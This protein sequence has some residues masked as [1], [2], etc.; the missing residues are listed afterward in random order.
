VSLLAA[1]DKHGYRRVAEGALARYGTTTDPSLANELARCAALV[2]DLVADHD[3][4]LR[5]AEFA[6][7]GVTEAGKS[8][9]S[10]TLGAALYRVGR[11]D[12]AIRRF[13]EG[14]KLGGGQGTPQDWAFLAMVHDRLAH[15]L[16]ARRWLTK[17]RAWNPGTSP[18]FSWE[19]V[20]I[21]ILHREAESVISDAQPARP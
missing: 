11:F 20:E 21:G 18:D 5:L 10:R 19:S 4:F 12:E 9:T 14:I 6:F 16:E 13:E 8:A 15:R 1:G 2:P 7:Q 3:D 17:L